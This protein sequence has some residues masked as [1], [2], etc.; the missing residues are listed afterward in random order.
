VFGRKN[1]FYNA[2]SFTLV[3]VV[4]VVANAIGYDF[5]KHGRESHWVGAPVFWELGLGAICAVVAA[6]WGVRARRELDQDHR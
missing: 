6:V 2:F 5:S 1:A 4:L 3:S